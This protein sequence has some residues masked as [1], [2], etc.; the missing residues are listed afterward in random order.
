[1]ADFSKLKQRRTLGAPPPPT[2]ASTNLAH[3][4]DLLAEQGLK[5]PPPQADIQPSR[6]DLGRF[7]RLDGR[8]LRRSNRIVQFATRV[9]PEFDRRIREIARDEH[10]L[11]V[12]VLE[13]ALEAYE[14]QQPAIGQKAAR[15]VVARR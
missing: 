5:P 7:D 10:L 1:M 8:S 3:P 9:T 4:E 13:R 12:E 14:R 6:E 2:E 11:I 15:S